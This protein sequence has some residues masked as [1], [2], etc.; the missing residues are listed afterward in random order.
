MSWRLHLTNQAIPYLDILEG[1]PVLLGVWSRYDRVAFYE[2]ES[3]TSAGEMPLLVPRPESR[4]DAEWQ[5]FLADLKAPNGS[6]LSRLRA[7]QG[8]IYLTDDGRMRL[9]HAPGSTDLYLDDNGTEVKLPV[10]DAESFRAVALD[11]FLGLTAALDETGKLHLYQ[12]HIR[13]G[14]FDLGI[15]AQADT[16][17]FIAISRGGNAIFVSDGSRLLVA[18]SSGKVRRQIETHY[19]VGDM[20]CSPDGRYLI[21]SDGDTGV[22]RVYDGVNLALMYQRFA[23]DLLAKATQLQL[24]ADLPPFMVGLSA[25]N[26][27]KRGEVVFAMSGIVCVSHIDDMDALPRAQPLL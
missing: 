6:F 20:A 21:A 2:L 25:L 11:R 15:N 9:V 27:G 7:P 19:F 10:S 12:Q 23:I 13:V 1:Q 16:R 14:A 5:S 4:A 8:N 24:M 17:L 18:D 22:L 26:I 3:G